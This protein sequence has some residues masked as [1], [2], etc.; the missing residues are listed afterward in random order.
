[1]PHESQGQSCI[2][3]WK[4]L[5]YISKGIKCIIGQ[6]SRKTMQKMVPSMWQTLK[7]NSVKN[8][9][10]QKLQIPCFKIKLF[11]SGKFFS[12]SRQRANYQNK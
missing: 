10:H 4:G 2:G 3:H 1:M 11:H 12:I 7:E 6:S 9:K 8:K 5:A